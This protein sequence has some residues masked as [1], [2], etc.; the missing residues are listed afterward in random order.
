MH[1][2][3]NCGSGPAHILEIVKKIDIE[4]EIVSVLPNAGYPEIIH[5]RTVYPNNPLYFAK[6][7]MK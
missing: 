1:L 6:K 4:N 7:V 5:E 2:G 3:S